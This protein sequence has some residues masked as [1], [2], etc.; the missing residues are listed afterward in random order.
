MVETEMGK[1]AHTI[2]EEVI[3][4]IDKCIMEDSKQFDR[5]NS[6]LDRIDSSLGQVYCSLDGVDSG[7]EG[8]DSNLEQIDSILDKIEENTK[9]L[10]KI[11]EM[12]K[13]RNNRVRS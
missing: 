9:L 12:V 3:A 8:V 7:L 10:P 2:G 4:H 13:V 6:K 11:L 5:I 1:S